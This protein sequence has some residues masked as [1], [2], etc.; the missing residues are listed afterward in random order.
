MKQI[1][2]SILLFP[3]I[4]F[5]QK[6]IFGINP[7][8]DA[9]APRKIYKS[10]YNQHEYRL[11][12]GDY[13]DSSLTIISDTNFIV[14]NGTQM[15]VKKAVGSTKITILN[16]NS[17]RVLYSNNIL[18]TKI[19]EVFIEINKDS[20]LTSGILMTK[21]VNENKKDCSN[22]FYFSFIEYELLDKDNKTIFREISEDFRNKID[23][24]YINGAKKI[25]IKARIINKENGLSSSIPHFEM[26]L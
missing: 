24:G 16:A 17:K 5:A 1:L 4:L 8:D 7:L 13:E 3:Q 18:I 6:F 20:L 22:K 21:L 26:D 11:T 2:I 23:S 12:F 9:S 19:P 10:L 25:I 15:L 14:I